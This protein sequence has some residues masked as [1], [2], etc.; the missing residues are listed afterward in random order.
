MV[1]L[2]ER[3]RLNVSAWRDHSVTVRIVDACACLTESQAMVRALQRII[4]YFPIT[5]RRG[6]VRAPVGKR[7]PFATLEP[8]QSNRFS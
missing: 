4:D 5:Q 7:N 3:V 1:P 8:I 2:D 6:S